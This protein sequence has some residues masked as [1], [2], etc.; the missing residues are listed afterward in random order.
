MITALDALGEA[1]LTDTISSFVPSA[2]GIRSERIKLAVG[3][4]T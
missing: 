4:N 3:S 1:F 2:S